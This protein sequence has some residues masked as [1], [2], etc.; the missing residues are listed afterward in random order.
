MRAYQKTRLVDLFEGIHEDW[1]Q[2]LS[3][4]FEKP[5]FLNL[6][7]YID[8]ARRKGIEVYPSDYQVFQALNPSVSL[9]LKLLAAASLKWQQCC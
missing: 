1:K 7:Q 5:Y 2:L 3:A 9:L 6:I 8:D 4:E